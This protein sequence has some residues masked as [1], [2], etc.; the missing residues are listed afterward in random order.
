MQRSGRGPGSKLR[1]SCSPVS[2]EIEVDGV[3][4]KTEYG[5]DVRVLETPQDETIAAH[6]ETMN[7]DGHSVVHCSGC[8]GGAP[9][10][11]AAPQC[12]G[13]S[14][15]QKCSGNSPRQQC[16]GSSLLQQCSGNSLD[17][18]ACVEALRLVARDFPRREWPVFARS[19]QSPRKG[20]RASTRTTLLA[21]GGQPRVLKK[22]GRAANGGTE[23]P[24]EGRPLCEACYPGWAK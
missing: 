18:P 8:E 11:T 15:V 13:N 9:Q 7:G 10:R 22:D 23:P 14:E 19:P 5:N 12:S 21:R 20:G 2:D 4:D 17:P 16:S 3:F 24:G 6:S 1:S